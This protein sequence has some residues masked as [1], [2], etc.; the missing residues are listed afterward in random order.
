[1]SKMLKSLLFRK[2]TRLYSGAKSLL[3]RIEN[4]ELRT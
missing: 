1:M 2:C 4:V 3:I